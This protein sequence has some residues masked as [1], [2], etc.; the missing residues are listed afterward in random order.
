[1]RKVLFILMLFISLQTMVQTFKPSL[2]S[3]CVW[4]AEAEQFNYR[5]NKW[6]VEFSDSIYTMTLLFS[7]NGE[8]VVKGSQY[9]LSEFIP[10]KFYSVKVGSGQKG[11]CLVIDNVSKK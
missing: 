3:G 9:H 8:T 1:M 6:T 11:G 2:L 4:V 10:E 7:H 5:G